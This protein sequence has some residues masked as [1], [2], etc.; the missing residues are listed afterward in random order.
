MLTYNRE[1]LV[2][3]AIESVTAQT[4]RD[5]EFIVVNNG[6]SDRSGAIADEYAAKD[7]RLRVI[8]RER[9]NIGSGRNTGLDAA[10]G[11]YIAFIDD[12][13]W[14][15]PDFLEFLYNLLTENN[16]DVSICGSTDKI[17]D[18]E[19]ILTAEEAL[20]T[21]F[22]RKYYN[23]AF[24]T[25]M[26]SRR[27]AKKIRFP[28]D[29]VYDDISQMHK[30]LAFSNRIVYHGLPKYTFHRHETNNSA[31]TT[32]H[33]LLDSK[34]LDEYLR[35]YRE[36]TEWLSELFPNN[37]AAW[38]YFEWSFMISMVEKVS[39]LNIKDCKEQ[40][41][42]MLNELRESR[43]IFLNSEFILDFEKEWVEKY[44]SI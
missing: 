9:G 7:N 14:C 24:P 32:N 23:V 35:T 44:V 1:A 41:S 38:R 12:D 30:L 37:A 31:W 8:H 2:G 26:F 36:R 39:R 16:A 15:E 22:W 42:T 6:S 13:D 33:N 5:F 10:T 29:D 4:F 20:T 11:E 40:L 21:L 3:R 25:K 17:F 34:T 43:N 18:E 19:F 27:L 28:E